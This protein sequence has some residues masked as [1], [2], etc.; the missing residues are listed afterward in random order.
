MKIC[1][2]ADIHGDVKNLSKAIEQ[3]EDS[4]DQFVVLGDVIY[5]QKHAHETVAML[6]RCGAVGVWGNHE[7]GLCIEPSDELRQAYGETVLEF[8][9]RLQAQMELGDYLFSHTLPDQDA[10]DPFSYYLGPSPHDMEALDACFAKFRHRAF[11]IGHFHRWLAVTSAG[12][13]MWNGELPLTLHGERRLVVIN[14][15]MNGW[16]AVLDDQAGVL[17]PVRL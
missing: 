15:V 9:S 4:V 17:T 7:L 1:L 11:L 2:L 13:L 12:P 16:A 14:A 6:N 8:F 3:L 5:D 10:S